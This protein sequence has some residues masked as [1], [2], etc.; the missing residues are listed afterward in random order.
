M[1]IIHVDLEIFILFP[2][3]PSDVKVK[4][5][6]TETL[7]HGPSSEI[8]LS[9]TDTSE[10]SGAT[11]LDTS[12]VIADSGPSV[13]GKL[14]ELLQKKGWPVPAYSQASGHRLVLVN[15][16]F[17]CIVLRRSKH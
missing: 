15:T 3:P 14:Q 9:K 4:T 10:P 13:K 11:A 7:I 12:T 6:P 8:G 1:G 17:P 16:S 5:L 2:K